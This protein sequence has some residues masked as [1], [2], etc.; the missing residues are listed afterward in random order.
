MIL[1]EITETVKTLCFL[2]L[3]GLDWSS[4]VKICFLSLLISCI[5]WSS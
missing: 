5:T 1:R 2:F 4:S 3:F